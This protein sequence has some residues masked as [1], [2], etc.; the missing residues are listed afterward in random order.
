MVISFK[1]SQELNKRW[2]S[3]FIIDSIR[4]FKWIKFLCCLVIFRTTSYG[5]RFVWSS[6]CCR[7]FIKVAKRF[8]WKHGKNPVSLWE[9]DVLLLWPGHNIYWDFV[10]FEHNVP[11][12]RARITSEQL[13]ENVYSLVVSTLLRSIISL[14]IKPV[15]RYIS[16]C[17]NSMACFTGSL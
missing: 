17:I 7:Y 8:L 1:V 4:S 3:C 14:T 10:N 15:S 5:C 16:F 12:T 2:K 13:P 11:K 9:E 6:W